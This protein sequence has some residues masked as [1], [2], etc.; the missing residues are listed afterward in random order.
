MFNCPHSMKLYDHDIKRLEEIR[1]YIC[2]SLSGDISITGL[3][4]RH[5]LSKATLKRHFRLHFAMGVHQFVTIKRLEKSVDL[6]MEH[7]TISEVAALVGY[8]DSSSFGRAFKMH[9][10]ITPMELRNAFV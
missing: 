4:A 3:T 8:K 2:E 1:K 9:F 10:G 5:G 7:R 6:L